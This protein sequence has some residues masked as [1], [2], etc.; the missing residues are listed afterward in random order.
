MFT[1]TCNYNDDLTRKC[2]DVTNCGDC[3]STIGCGCNYFNFQDGVW[4][5]VYQAQ[6]HNQLV[7]LAKVI[8]YLKTGYLYFMI[9]EI[10]I[11]RAIKQIKFYLL[12]KVSKIYRIISILINLLKIKFKIDIVTMIIG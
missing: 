2:F 11:F 12:N 10:Q 7:K 5:N 6:N 4:T 8:V 1:P 3:T 9:A